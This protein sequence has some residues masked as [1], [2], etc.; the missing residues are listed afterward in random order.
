MLPTL[1]WPALAP[2]VIWGVNQH[3]RLHVKVL[4]W[5]KA[6][7]YR[8]SHIVVEKGLTVLNEYTFQDDPARR[9]LC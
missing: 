2:A 9:A 7:R 4:S 8:G 3:H 5:I 1:E 6:V